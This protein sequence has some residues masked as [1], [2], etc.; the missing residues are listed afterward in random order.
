MLDLI[1]DVIRLCEVNLVLIPD[2]LA[3]RLG[4]ERHFHDVPG[5]VIEQA[6]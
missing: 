4:L 3:L 2:D 1:D 5:L 6:M